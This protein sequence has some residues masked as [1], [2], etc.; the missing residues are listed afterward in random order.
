MRK[1]ARI[2]ASPTLERVFEMTRLS[3][4]FYKGKKLFPEKLQYASSV[5]TIPV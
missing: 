5:T 2:A 1:P 3:Y 4:F